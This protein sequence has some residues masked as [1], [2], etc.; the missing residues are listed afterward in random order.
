M[1]TILWIGRYVIFFWSDERKPLEPVHVHVA[2]GRPS[3]NSAK[4]WITSDGKVLLE[5]DNARIPLKV[6]RRVIKVVEERSTL[7]L[8]AWQEYFCE[9]RY[10][11]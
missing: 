2:L 4:L 5:H 11:R 7:I 8:A 1:P 3:T 6:M 9:I 10:I